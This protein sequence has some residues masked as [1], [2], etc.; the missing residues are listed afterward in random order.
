MQDIDGYRSNERGADNAITLLFQTARSRRA[1]P[2][3][4]RQD[5]P[6]RHL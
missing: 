2:D 5:N 6:S 1:V 3:R 4:E